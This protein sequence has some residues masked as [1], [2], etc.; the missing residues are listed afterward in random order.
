MKATLYFARGSNKLAC[1]EEKVIIFIRV[2]YKIVSL[3]IF[4]CVCICP[5]D[6]TSEPLTFNPVS[7]SAAAHRLTTLV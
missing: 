6:G 1:Q 3:S 4:S 7:T 2:P 5:G